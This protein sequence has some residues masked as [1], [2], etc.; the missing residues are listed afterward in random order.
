[1]NRAD[2]DRVGLEYESAGEGEPMVCIHGALIADAFRPLRAEP[3]LAEQFRLVTY[4]RR[5]YGGTT[6]S[7][8]VTIAWHAA[9][10]RRR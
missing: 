10:C 5:G 8:P 9:D 6:V 4:R 3:T 1:M 2:V 7:G